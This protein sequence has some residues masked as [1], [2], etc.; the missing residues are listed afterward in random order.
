MILFLTHARESTGF[1]RV[2]DSIAAQLPFAIHRLGIDAS[3][4]VIASLNPD[5][6]L[7]VAE[8]WVCARLAPA[9]CDRYATIF[10]AAVDGEESVTGSIAAELGRADLVVAFGQFGREI[11]QRRMARRVEVIPHGV[12]GAVFHRVDR[13]AA[14]AEL[15]GPDLADAFLVLNAN[16][17]QP[18]KRIDITME[19][20]ALFA[21]DKPEQVRLC[22]HMATRAAGPGEVTLADRFGIR[23]R[24]LL[25]VRSERHPSFSDER[26][27]LLYNACD[28]GLN[29]SER[30]GWG[31][32][33]FE[34][35]AT[36]AAQI[37]PRHTACAEL[38]DG[39]AMF[40][41]PAA[42]DDVSRYQHA[43]RTVRAEAVAEALDV[44][45]ADACERERL[46]RAAF[47]RATEPRY[48]W[49]AIAAR[50]QEVFDDVRRTSPR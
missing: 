28:I 27:N 21:R 4:A 29:T 10:Y 39:A 5:L 34:H 47:A 48:S 33:A 2:V 14:R 7:V 11:L 37:V 31:L 13:R 41:D 24:L 44:L 3:P 30:E 16:R 36:G 9:L 19:A 38:W 22:L 20:F 8:P 35:A 26:L 50:W 49:T 6:V 25:T 42:N 45:Y 17:N 46:G 23:D 32:V 12:D 18:F 43:G 15:F 40:V 1:A